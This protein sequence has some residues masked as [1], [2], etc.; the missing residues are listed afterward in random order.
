MFEEDTQPDTEA[1]YSGVDPV[2]V[3]DLNDV[4]E[5]RAYIP[6][7]Q[8]VKMRIQKVDVRASRE[9][10]AEGKPANIYRSLNLQL[11]IVDG[12]DEEGKYRNKV[13]FG[14][15]CYY[16]DPVYYTKDFFKKRQ[17]LV[18]LKY[19]ANATGVDLNKVNGYKIEELEGK[20]VLANITVRKRPEL[21]AGQ[22]VLDENSK[23]CFTFDNEVKNY[24]AIPTDQLV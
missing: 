16:A 2:D 19:L 13:V 20:E 11:K 18:Q 14:R 9:N 8:N 3:G 22:P 12:V 7:A 21:L 1:F 15:V 23:P 24:K 5:E 10:T 17:H 4:K 6:A